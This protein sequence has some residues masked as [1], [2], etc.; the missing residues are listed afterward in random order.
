MTTRKLTLRIKRILCSAAKNSRCERSGTIAFYRAGSQILLLSLSLSTALP[1]SESPLSFHLLSPLL[2]VLTRDEFATRI[3]EI[4]EIPASAWCGYTVIPSF[5]F[6]SVFTARF[7]SSSLPSY[8]PLYTCLRPQSISEG[9]RIFFYLW[10]LR[11]ISSRLV[12]AKLLLN[13]TSFAII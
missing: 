1:R 2:A 4:R 6:S 7:L 9:F 12:F 13:I 8:S 5:L 3:V 11:Q 10:I